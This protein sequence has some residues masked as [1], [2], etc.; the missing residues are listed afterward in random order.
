MSSG[1]EG[2]CSVPVIYLG[3]EVELRL[4]GGSRQLWDPLPDVFCCRPLPP[5]HHICPRVSVDLQLP[6]GA[7]AAQEALLAF[8]E[9]G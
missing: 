4:G 3:V 1:G 8:S 7:L 6:Q 2:G 5:S 9:N